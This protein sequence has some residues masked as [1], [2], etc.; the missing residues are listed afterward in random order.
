MEYVVEGSNLDLL[1]IDIIALYSNSND[2]PTQNI[3]V[4]NPAVYGAPIQ[5]SADSITFST[6]EYYHDYNYGTPHYLGAIVN[7]FTKEIYW[8]NESR[9]L[10]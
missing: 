4:I 3:E 5:R 1:P 8:V 2:N 9:P 6:N 10:P 7:R